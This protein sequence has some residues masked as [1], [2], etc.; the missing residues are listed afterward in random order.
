MLEQIEK[1]FDNKLSLAERQVFENQMLT[2]DAFAKEV[3][4]YVQ[5]RSASKAL[6]NDKRKQE[7]EALRQKLTNSKPRNFKPIIWLSGL[8]ASLMIGF[9]LWNF[10]DSDAK[11]TETLAEAYIQQHFENLPVKMDGKTDSLQLGLRLFNEHKLKESQVIFEEIYKKENTNS[12]A[13]K[14]AGITA[15]KLNQYEKAINYFKLLSLQKD[16]YANPGIF[17][18]AITLLKKSP[19]DK[20]KAKELLKEVVAKNL[21]GSE[22]ARKILDEF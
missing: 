18:E 1:Y 12:E 5:T 13:I 14:Y 19:Q 21:E 10:M 3:A 2:D 8:A 17:Y 9:G 11:S 16:L 22:E 15:L 7:F 20:E 6:A 4:F